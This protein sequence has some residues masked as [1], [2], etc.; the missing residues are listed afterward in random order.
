MSDIWFQKTIISWEN[1]MDKPVIHAL[2]IANILMFI[3]SGW[4]L[5]SNLIKGN[6]PPQTQLI[7]KKIEPEVETKPIQLIPAVIQNINERNQQIHSFACEDI[8]VKLWESR[9]RVKLT[10]KLY[11]EKAS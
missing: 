7:N 3:A 9:F 11:Y 1:N 10:G 2:V 4:M 8:K 5:G 6:N